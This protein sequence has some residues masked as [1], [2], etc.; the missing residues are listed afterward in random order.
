[1]SVEAD[2]TGSMNT[3]TLESAHAADPADFA[4]FSHRAL[5]GKVA[6]VAGATRGAGRAIARDLA[7]A[8]A[9]VHC[10]G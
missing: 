5:S 3:P 6:L 2:E 7:R 9:F 8:G 10:T 1:M 4:P